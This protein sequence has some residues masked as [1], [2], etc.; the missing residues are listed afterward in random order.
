MFAPKKQC[1]LPN[2]GTNI[3]GHISNPFPVG[4]VGKGRH[5]ELSIL[6]Y[7]GQHEQQRR[8]DLT[9]RLLA[10][11]TKNYSAIFRAFS[12]KTTFS[13]DI[14]PTRKHLATAQKDADVVPGV[15]SRNPAL[16]NKFAVAQSSLLDGKK[17]RKQRNTA[18]FERAHTSERLAASPSVC[19][20]HACTRTRARSRSYRS[21]LFPL[22]PLPATQVKP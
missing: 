3:N 11:R 12:K 2:P 6:R 7:L 17:E 15:S 1:L 10:P 9:P 18:N 4:P 8:A 19:T 21:Y 14:T 22:E 20:S 13:K 5:I 16:P